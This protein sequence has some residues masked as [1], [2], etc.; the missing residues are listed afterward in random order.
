MGWSVNLVE[1]PICGCLH[2]DGLILNVDKERFL[3]CF[4]CT[5]KY[6]K[7]EL[8]QKCKAKIKTMYPRHYEWEDED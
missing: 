2:D 7:N 4:R 1:C 5:E 6:S 3:V 8:I